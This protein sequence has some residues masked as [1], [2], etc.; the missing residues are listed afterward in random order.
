MRVLFILVFVLAAICSTAAQTGC[1]SVTVTNDNDIPLA[2]MHAVVTR[3]YPGEIWF[4]DTDERGRFDVTGLPA[5]N[6]TI[7]TRNMDLGYPDTNDFDFT[8]IVHPQGIAVVESDRC[9][10]VRVRREPPAGKLHLKLTDE[11]SRVFI[12]DP[13]AQFR[14]IDGHYGWNATTQQKLDLLVPA[15]KPIEVRVGAKGYK[16]TAPFSIQPLQPGEVRDFTVVLKPV[17]LGC[18]QGKV[19]DAAAQPVAGI[20]VQPLLVNDNLNSKAMSTKTDANG[21]FQMLDLPPGRY[22]VFV[23]SKEM[24]YD[25]M[26][27]L[28]KGGKHPEVEVP[29]STS[30][31]EITLNLTEPNGKL[32]VEA[33]DAATQ[34]PIQHFHFEVQSTVPKWWWSEGREWANEIQMPPGREYSVKAEAEGYEASQPVPLAVFTS[35]E[36]R[37]ITIQLQP[38]NKGAPKP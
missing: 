24:G 10:E 13:I 31:A 2:N 36:V 5:G 25:S 1:I 21:E 29:A 17:G 18:L 27:M 6:Y 7:I 20:K 32:V 11:V 23:Y 4:R 8:G 16:S 37:R 9:T 30:C 38:M 28:S 35:G 19:L 22:F 33:I 26:S 15:S 12:E 3:G 34:A 14:R